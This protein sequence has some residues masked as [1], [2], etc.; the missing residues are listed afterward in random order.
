MYV[1]TFNNNYNIIEFIIIDHFFFNLQFYYT[2][3]QNHMYNIHGTYECIHIFL[4]SA[5]STRND[6]DLLHS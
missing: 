6:N 2:K 4:I 5:F 3:S 1:D